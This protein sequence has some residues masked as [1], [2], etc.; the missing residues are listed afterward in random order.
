M[1][2]T[3]PGLNMHRPTR[4]S[5][6]R[7]DPARLRSGPRPGTPLTTYDISYLRSD[8]QVQRHRQTAPASPTFL[9]AFSAF[10]RGTLITTAQGP[11]AVEDLEPGMKLITNERGP[12]PLLWIGSMM[13]APQARLFGTGVPVLTRIMADALGMGRPMTDVVAGPS[14]RLLHRSPGLADQILQPVH[15]LAD[16]VHVIGANPPSPVQLFHLALYRHATIT[17]AGLPAETFHPGPGYEAALP[18]ED[19]ATFL[20]LF[21]HVRKS[22]D[23][24]SLAHPRQPLHFSGQY[25][26]A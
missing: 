20:G 13:L 10:A 21:P 8:G 2:Y 12:S 22:S 24:G 18:Y 5:P 23:F 9:A 17:V 7:A 3:P 25:E 15:I 11:V 16:G 14:A 4:L 26:L 6:G 19:H 1:V